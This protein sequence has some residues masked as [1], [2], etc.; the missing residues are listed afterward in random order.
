MKV[1]FLFLGGKYNFTDK[2]ISQHC[3]Y[4]LS[5]E[6]KEFT[7]HL[8]VRCNISRTNQRR[9][10]IFSC[11]AL[12]AKTGSGRAAAAA[13]TWSWA[14]ARFSHNYVVNVRRP[15]RAGVNLIKQRF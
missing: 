9:H 2:C 13:N 7:T 5:G 3:P 8:L 15:G 11:F 1:I 10:G 12:A 4:R 6:G 14:A